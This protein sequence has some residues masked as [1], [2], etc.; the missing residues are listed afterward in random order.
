MK[1]LAAS[2]LYCY[3]SIVKMGAIFFFGFWSL[4]MGVLIMPPLRLLVHP[5]DR[6]K[7]L[8]RFIIFHFFRLFVAVLVLLRGIQ[9][10]V[11]DRKRYRTIRS[12]VIV[13]NHPSLLDVVILLSLIPNADCI[14]N[15]A[16]SKSPLTWVIR[17][18]YIVNSLDFEDLM[19][20]CRQSLESGTNILIFPEGTRTPHGGTT[21]FKR[22]AARIAYEAGVDLQPLYMGGNEKFGLGKHDPLF[23]YNKDEIYRY[24]LFL[25]P[26]IPVQDYKNLEPQI[27][28]RR[29]TERMHEV[30]ADEALRRDGRIL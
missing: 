23:S 21:P 18:L 16:L 24:N 7:K 1:R 19:V 15:G 3:R 22:G 27:A 14:V 20:K 28:S 8:S 10:T 12:K 29:M 11:D 6:F 2:V 13:A 25:L 17:Q 5:A 9:L 30:L 4:I 26:P